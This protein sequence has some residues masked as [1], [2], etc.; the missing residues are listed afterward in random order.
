M[1]S[2]KIIR[3]QE[4][5]FKLTVLECCPQNICLNIINQR[6]IWRSSN[7]LSNVKLTFMKEDIYRNYF[8]LFKV[9]NC[10]SKHFK[11]KNLIN[12]VIAGSNAMF[13]SLF[14]PFN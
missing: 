12:T 5:E 10:Q 14:T 9:N 7:I 6:I 8:D 4:N 13:E 3:I 2:L 1:C 11:I